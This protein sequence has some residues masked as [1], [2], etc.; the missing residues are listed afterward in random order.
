MSLRRVR[1]EAR[2]AY[3]GFG[4]PA[5]PGAAVVQDAAGERRLLFTGDRD[6]AR[7][8]WPDAEVEDAGFALS[9][10]PVNAHLHLDLSTMPYLERSYEA[11]VRDVLAHGRQ[12]HRGAAAAR[13]GLDE[14]A[15]AGT[16]TF[17]DV[18]ADEDTMHMLLDRAGLRGV[19]YWEVIAPDPADAERVFDD[20]VARLRAFRARQRPDGLRVGLSPHAPHTLSA[21]LLRDLARLA[22]ANDLPMQ[23]HVAETA[24]EAQLH[25]H[26]DGPLRDLMGPLLADFRPSGLSPVG[27]L[28]SLGVLEAGPTLVH[29]ADVDEDDVARIQH[30][31]CTVVHCPRSN[32]ALG[33]PR[34][35]WETYARHGVTVAFGTDS[36]GSSPSLDVQEE[37]AAAAALHG[38]RAAPGALV[39]A[40]VKG[41]YRA[42]A[43]TPPRLGRGSAADGLVRWH[44]QPPGAAPGEAGPVSGA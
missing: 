20:T 16:D 21:P 30:G 5:S 43:L 23:I 17:G 36:K 9:P 28:A 39:R 3:G 35:P 44:V 29:A 31:G 15:A 14:L 24:S 27:Y 42:L 1:W 22:S 40:A 7:R 13:A 26:G 37:V 41:G 32:A 8:R 34:F 2:V 25:R 11:F 19:A 12:G 38:P 18:V 6:E 10:P 4:T 33:A